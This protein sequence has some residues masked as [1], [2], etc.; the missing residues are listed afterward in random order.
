MSLMEPLETTIPDELWNN[1][2]IL[3]HKTG[4]Q[5][6]A[7]E[8]YSKAGDTTR[9]LKFNK[10]RWHEDNGR[11]AEAKAIYETL[12]SY[13]DAKLRLSVMAKKE[14]DLN[15]ALAHCRDV[16]AFDKKPINALCQ[17]G[18]IEFDVGDV[19]KALDTFN[20]VIWK[21]SHH[22]LYALLS[23]G[24][25]H[26]EKALTSEREGYMKNALDY[27]RK[28]LSLDERNAYAAVGIGIYLAEMGRL[29]DA[30]E[31][32]RMVGDNMPNLTSNMVN[33][34]HIH[35]L[36]RRY[37]SAIKLYQK[38]SNVLP[39]NNVDVY[40]AFTYY[41]LE[42]YDKSIE[43]L[44]PL[45]DAPK[46]NPKHTFNLALCLHSSALMSINNK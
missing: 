10:A 19:K 23:M 20:R 22:D 2:G 27:F 38:A 14:K 6:G 36:Q 11:D 8:A 4:N 44:R 37:E 32:F 45:L 16:L 17:K 13:S 9:T 40:I 5:E 29:G 30:F 41:C 31:A 26:Y 39:G 21:H 12:D 15:T 43:I 33:L 28:V 18:S 34:A 1:L 7:E 25:L 42:K 3:R 35:L 46:Y 24:N